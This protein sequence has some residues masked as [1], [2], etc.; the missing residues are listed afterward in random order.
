[1]V[2]GHLDDL[3]AGSRAH[4]ER[5]ARIGAAHRDQRLGQ[6]HRRRHGH[7]A[8]AEPVR[9]PLADIAGQS[10]DRLHARQRIEHFGH[11]RAA[12]AGETQAPLLAAEQG[13]AQ[14][15]FHIAQQRAG[16]RL[17]H[18]DRGGGGGDRVMAVHRAQ[19][20]QFSAI[21]H[22]KIIWK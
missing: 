9:S 2:H 15:R 8:D 21:K 13:K 19:Q 10:V 17:G 3:Q 11:Q 12:L 5:D 4:G 18:V 7:R 6:Q 16:R 20:Q 1:M 22:M 14:A